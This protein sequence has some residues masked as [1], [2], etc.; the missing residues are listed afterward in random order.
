MNSS[1]KVKYISNWIKSYVDQMPTK[2]ESLVIGISGGIDSSVSSTLS[3]MTGLKT[4][5]LS[6]PIKQKKST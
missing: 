5:V 2:A 3:A 6:M 4:I 1:E